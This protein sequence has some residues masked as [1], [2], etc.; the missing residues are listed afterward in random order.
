MGESTRPQQ[1][2]VYKSG[3][4]GGFNQ[5]V[6]WLYL[7]TDQSECMNQFAVPVK[8]VPDSAEDVLCQPYSAAAAE[9]DELVNCH[10]FSCN[11][12]ITMNLK[13]TK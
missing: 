2:A 7:V 11:A 1:I 10:S 13:K 12:S 6:R 3:A 4:E 9:M 8:L 5:L